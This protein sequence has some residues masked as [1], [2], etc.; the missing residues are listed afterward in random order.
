[1]TIADRVAQMHEKAATQMPAEIMAT[2]RAEQARMGADGVPWGA[3]TVGDV[4][5]DV[6]LLDVHG[7][8]ITL[9]AAQAGAA[10]VVVLYRGEWCPYCNLALR[11]Y[12]E[13]L[14][15][16]LSDRG[17]RLIAVSPQKPDKSLSAQE[18]NALTFVVLSDPGNQI[19]TALGVLTSHSEQVKDVQRAMGIDVAGSNQDGTHTV[20]VPTV[21][22][23]DAGGTIRWIDIHP[24]YTT[25]TEVS[26]I[27]AGLDGL[28]EMQRRLT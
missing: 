15:P 17:I 7:K 8:P 1:M 16:A 20:P 11:T 21:A 28:V 10:A 9:R 13:E 27:L 25:R 5:P 2:F 22:V 14:V 26:D 23:I 18:K 12:Q 6:E 3:A 24:D 4:I 19:A